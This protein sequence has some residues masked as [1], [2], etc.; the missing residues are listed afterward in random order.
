M[1]DHSLNLGAWALLPCEGARAVCLAQ[2]ET[3]SGRWAKAGM[4]S[5][6]KNSRNMSPT[7]LDQ[8]RLCVAVVMSESNNKNSR[9]GRGG[10]G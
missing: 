4:E 2:F 5:S 8:K 1:R 10:V 3:L 9:E 7:V 6:N